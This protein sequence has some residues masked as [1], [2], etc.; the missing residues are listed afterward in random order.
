MTFIF[1]FFWHGKIHR[2]ANVHLRPSS[3]PYHL[4][5]QRKTD[6]NLSS[7][8]RIPV[9]SLHFS[10]YVSNCKITLL[11]LVLVVALCPSPCHPLP[12]RT[13]PGNVTSVEF[14]PPILFPMVTSNV[15]HLGGNVNLLY[16]QCSQEDV[17]NPR[18]KFF[19]SSGLSCCGFFS[20]SCVN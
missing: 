12:N 20:L 13:V 10:L 4:T 8:N 3:R 5:D 6:K 2:H 16:H 18:K 17:P 11:T 9:S 19:S 15:P 1:F 14:L 7:I